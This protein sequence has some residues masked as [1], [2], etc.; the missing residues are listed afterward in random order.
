[1]DRTVDVLIVTA[2]DGEDTAVKAVD[3]GALGPWEET[4]GPEGYGFKVWFRQYET[5]SGRPLRVA[6]TRASDMGTDAA[7]NAAG[8]LT[9]AYKPQCLAMCGV[10]A[11]R[12]GW[13]NLGDVIIADRVYRYDVGEEGTTPGGKTVF[14]PDITTYP[15][16]PQ[17]R[18][19]AQQYRVPADTVWLSM[20]PRSRPMQVDWVLAELHRGQNP[21]KAADRDILCSDWT[22]VFQQ[23]MGKGFIVLKDGNPTL[24]DAGRS[25]IQDVLF[26]HGDQLPKQDAWRTVVGPLGTGSSLVRSADIWE[27][28]RKTERLVVGLDMEASAVGM[29][30]HV[31]DVPYMIVAKGVMDYAEPERNYGF[32]AFAARAAAEVLIGFLRRHLEPTAQRALHDFLLSNIREP[33]K[34]T[35]PAM[36]LNAR[37]EVVPFFEEARTAELADLMAWCEN[38]EVTTSVRLFHGSG[39]TGKTR[40]FIEWAKRLRKQGWYAGFLPERVD[41]DQVESILH[42]DKPTLVVLDYAECR[43]ALHEFVKRIA[44]RSAEQRERLRIALLARHVGDW[45]Q[46]LLQRDEAV[47]HLLVQ[48]EPVPITPIAV[49]GPLRTRIW[50][51]ARDVFT[52]QLEKSTPPDLIDLEDQR[53][54][55]ILYLH[56]SALAAVERLGTKAESLVGEIAVHERHFW[57]KR[58]QEQFG[59][60][61]FEAADFDRR[62]GRLV[63]AVTLLGG[64]PSR[65]AAE[66]LS[67][68]VGG[69]TSCYQHLVPFLRSLYPGRGQAAQDRYMGGL[70]PDLLGEALVWSVL[71]DPENAPQAFLDDVFTDTDEMTLRNGF[72]VLGRVSLQNP[73]IAEPWLAG[74]LEADIPNRARPAFLAA[75]GLASRTAFSPLGLILARALERE[76]TL[77]QAVEFFPLVPL[78]TV[79]LR[80]VALWTVRRTLEFVRT[81]EEMQ[82]NLT[83][84]A[85]LLSKLGARLS[86]LGRREEALQVTQEALDI[87]RQLAKDR[88]DAFLPNVATSL[89][90]IGVRHTDLGQREEALQADRE[91]ID[92]RR[93]L[94]ND[95]PDAFL[96]DLSMSL[97]NLGSSLSQ[98]GRPKEALQATQEAVDI[99]RR[100]AKDRPDAFLPELAMSV[101]NLGILLGDLGRREKALQVAQEALDIYRR[102]A[103]DRP[104]AFLPELAAS[105]GNLCSRLRDLGR[106]EETLQVAQEAVDIRRR[107]ANNRPDAF[108]PDLAISLNTLGV[109]LSDLGRL[110]E[111]LPAAQEA[112]G[113]YRR[114]AKNWPDAFLPNLATSLNTLGITLSGLGQREKALQAAKEVLDTYRRLA[115]D[116]PDAFLPNLAMSLNNLGNRLRALS[117]SEEALHAV[118]NAVD[119]Y[120]QL[121]KDRPNA[122]LPELAVSLNSLSDMLDDLGRREEALEGAQEALDIYRRLAADWPGAFLPNLAVSL[123]TLAERLNYLGRRERALQ[124]AQ[125]SVDIHRRLAKDQP[126]TFLPDLARSLGVLGTCLAAKA[127][128]REAVDV[129]GEGVHTLSPAFWKLPKV[130]AQLMAMLVSGYVT[131]AKEAGETPDIKLLAPIVAKFEEIKGDDGESKE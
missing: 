23:L 29:V 116:R 102:L 65:E 74:V 33:P 97:N 125:E 22:P 12:P 117:R 58:Y 7:V 67:Q 119:I 5:G 99:Q 121:A 93:R 120:R 27:R 61:D 109:I 113:V 129:F 17:W 14:Y 37:Y 95:R 47:R 101:H 85:G 114:L 81:H 103:K 107:L 64:A 111:A 126:D 71:T 30:A 54:G 50:K 92:I 13:A 28:L 40:L 98:L 10:C 42:T 55:R 20:R 128:L 32:R 94:A 100:L 49:E 62:C 41:D 36:L 89:S 39:G 96:P 104:D 124:I 31:Q 24:T 73:S 57:A 8:R 76:G 106:R 43:T 63:A 1:M 77:D 83:D 75:L 118:Q 80:E 2:A 90:D 45:W 115:K 91:A 59:E 44:A 88:P 52:A 16:R 78:R 35:N 21:L 68:R 82:E 123:S 105:L 122:I 108:L 25:Y 38:D 112:V 18:Q 3:E 131:Q 19:L 4:N 87:Y 34:A 15:F 46:S 130:F 69:P 86:D 56:M 53:F 70:E 72:V 79:S 60:D 51:H 127:R 48:A 110:E 11:G 26:K 6:M 84:L 66:A 9:D